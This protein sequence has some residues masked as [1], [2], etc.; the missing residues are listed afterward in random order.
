[1]DH[2]Y[3]VTSVLV[4]FACSRLY[5]FGAPEFLTLHF[6]MINMTFFEE[7]GWLLFAKKQKQ[8]EFLSSL[9]FPV[10]TVSTI[11][12]LIYFIL[13]IKSNW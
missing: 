7:L 1:M 6:I 13:L 3:L 2:I 11:Y 9:S 4:V 12:N 10:C 5:C 8:L